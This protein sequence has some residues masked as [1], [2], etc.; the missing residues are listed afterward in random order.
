MA[1]S[2]QPSAAVTSRLLDWYET[3]RRELSWRGRSDPYEIWVSE[4]ML[5]QTRAET[6]ERYYEPFLARFPTVADL[7]RADED[8]VLAAWSGLGY[9][10]R[11]RQLHA[12]A[13]AVADAGG[14]LPSTI[15]ELRSLPGIGAYT[16]AAIA[17]LAFGIPEP[18]LD[19]NVERVLSRYGAVEEEPKRAAGRDALLEL[20][21]R[22]MAPDRPGDFNQAM[23]E[24]GARLCTPRRP[25]CDSCPL[26]VD[27]IAREQGTQDLFPLRGPRPAT[28]REAWVAVVV[29][30]DDAVLLARRSST[31]GLLAGMWEL[32]GVPD[33]GDTEAALAERYGGCWKLESTAGRFRHAIT[34]RS[35]TVNV[36]PGRWEPGEI[37]EPGRLEWF[38]EGRIDSIPTT[39]MV[40][41]ALAVDRPPDPG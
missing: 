8:E 28:V 39:S 24:L 9:Y 41:K 31:A 14:E 19:G 22:L 21:H 25:G 34:H 10:R 36:H 13:R 6:V 32:P 16:A 38:R 27:C 40:G 18:V 7:A 30:R 33:T 12:A 1:T 37:A 3:D 26:A 11:A 5:Q 20:A 17:S 29:R 35:L 23:M 15:A 4:I 2:A